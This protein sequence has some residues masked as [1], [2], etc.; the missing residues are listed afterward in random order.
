MDEEGQGADEREARG[1][2]RRNKRKRIRFVETF[3]YNALL[4]TYDE[5]DVQ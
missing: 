5:R 3:T 2:T 4:K 1:G